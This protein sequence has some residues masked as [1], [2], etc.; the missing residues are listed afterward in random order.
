MQNQPQS[1]AEIVAEMRQL[2]VVRYKSGDIEVELGPS[3]GAKIDDE[4]AERSRA[5]AAANEKERKLDTLFKA[6]GIRPVIRNRDIP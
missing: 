6:S 2:G 5:Q 4:Q 1:L 3:K